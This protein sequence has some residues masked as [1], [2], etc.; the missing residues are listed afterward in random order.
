MA[1]FI[2]DNFPI[3]H[4]KNLSDGND[5][6]QKAIEVTK[7]QYSTLI[8]LLIAVCSPHKA[9]LLIWDHCK[10]MIDAKIPYLILF[11]RSLQQNAYST[12]CLF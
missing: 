6:K 2:G 5:N 7:I 1:S 3:Q 8:A 4:E 10:E 9:F 11:F 12:C